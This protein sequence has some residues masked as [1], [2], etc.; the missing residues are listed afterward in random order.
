MTRKDQSGNL[1]ARRSAIGQALAEGAAFLIAL[2]MVAVAVLLLVVGVA[3]AHYYHMRILDLA[4]VL[5]KAVVADTFWE[6]NQYKPKPTQ[7]DGDHQQM[8]T[9]YLSSLG[10]PSG[11]NDWTATVTDDGNNNCVVTLTV[12]GLPILGCGI[13]PQAISMSAS[14]VQPWYMGHPPFSVML[15]TSF[16]QVIV[17]AYRPIPQLTSGAPPILAEVDG[18]YEWTA[19]SGYSAYGPFDLNYGGYGSSAPAGSSTATGQVVASFA[20]V[21][22][23][24]YPAPPA[25]VYPQ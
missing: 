4:D 11:S 13:L 16:G 19:N 6:G 21:S 23:T 20:P 2:T 24:L 8:V 9:S 17:P 15:A 18:I 3:S 7:L 25:S 22:G 5:A 10:L 14:A 1:H 12:K